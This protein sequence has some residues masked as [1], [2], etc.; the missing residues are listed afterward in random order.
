MCSLCAAYVRPMCGAFGGMLVAS[1]VQ[2]DDF[3]V[4]S[5]HHVVWCTA[6]VI[7]LLHVWVCGVLEVCV[8]VC[9]FVT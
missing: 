9:V 4:V 7:G 5:F 6:M 2:F 1:C 8:C 3:C